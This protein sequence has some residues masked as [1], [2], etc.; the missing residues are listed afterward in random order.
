MKFS[1]DLKKIMPY[2]KGIEVIDG[3]L[4]V[5]L[6]LE[7]GWFCYEKKGKFSVMQLKEDENIWAV[8]CNADSQESDE[9]F[10]FI[11]EIISTNKSVRLKMDL[12]K[13]KINELKELFANTP[14]DELLNLKFV[15]DK[16]E[17]PKKKRP[18][19]KKPKKTDEVEETVTMDDT[20]TNNNEEKQEEVENVLD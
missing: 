14:F 12:L 17:E 6:K 4:I 18:Y 11:D 19:H 13:I 10:S 7:R 15:I 9:I 20:E 3:R 8:M 2:F 5:K 1:E 16:Q